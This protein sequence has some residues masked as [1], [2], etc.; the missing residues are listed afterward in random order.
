MG[1]RRAQTLLLLV[2]L[3]FQLLERTSEHSGCCTAAIE[4]TTS[5]SLNLAT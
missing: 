4:S 5:F 3:T 1:L 2:A